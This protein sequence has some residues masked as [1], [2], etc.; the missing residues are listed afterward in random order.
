MAA[1]KP[2]PKRQ[3]G[4]WLAIVWLAIVVLAAVFADVQYRTGVMDSAIKP[5][6][7][8]K[9]CGQAVTVQLSK[10]DLVDPLKLTAGKKRHALVVLG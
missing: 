1:A 5:A 6:F 3:V 8:A 4:L 2:R 10:G 9:I 7:R